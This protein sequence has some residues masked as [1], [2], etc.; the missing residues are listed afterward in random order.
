MKSFRTLVILTLSLL[1][2]SSSLHAET[3]AEPKSLADILS[4]IQASHEKLTE[5]IVAEDA[6]T[7]HSIAENLAAASLAMIE[8]LK[9][10]DEAK[11]KS[12]TTRIR[13]LSRTYEKIHHTVEVGAFA[14]ATKETAMAKASLAHIETQLK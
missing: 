2:F 1:A 3:K 6:K 7:A 11:T 8:Q 13:V 5:A 4:E 14:D 9:G 10:F 12:L